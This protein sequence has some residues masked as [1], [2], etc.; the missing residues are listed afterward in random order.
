MRITG[1]SDYSYSVV[2]VGHLARKLQQASATQ[3]NVRQVYELSTNIMLECQRIRE[4]TQN[5]ASPKTLM[6]Y[7]KQ[8]IK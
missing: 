4:C 8:I 5:E 3:S 7:I 1:N 6:D 2:T